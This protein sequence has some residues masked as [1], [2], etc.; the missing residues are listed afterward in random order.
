MKILRALLIGAA[1][2][3][4]AIAV[5]AFIW[6]LTLNLTILNR[7]AVKT[8]L[9]D[10]NLYSNLLDS[11]FQTTLSQQTTQLEGLLTPDILKTAL[12]NTFQPSYIQTQSETALDS[13]YNW[14]EGTA[15]T[16]NFTIDIPAK[17]DTFIQELTK[18][19]T[20]KVAALP[21]CTD[22]QLVLQEA[23]C[24]PASVTPEQFSKEIA[25]NSVASADFFDKPLTGENLIGE[26]TPQAAN[27]D[28]QADMQLLS[29]LP[30]YRQW[31][32]ILIIALPILIVIC[33]SLVILLSPD[34]LF[35]TIRLSRRLFFGAV[36]T[37]LA[38]LVMLY[39]GNNANSLPGLATQPAANLFIPVIQQVITGIATQLAITSGSFAATTG[40]AWLIT[41]LIRRKQ[42]HQQLLQPPAGTPQPPQPPTPPSTIN[43]V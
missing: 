26:S 40:A 34:K 2:L 18:V 28:T 14:I 23:T 20:P 13:T 15:T 1:T 27:P 30:V 31:V 8:W 37:F 6:L 22:L 32:N 25:E 38:A 10:S 41:A 7:Q 36:L 12:Q 29:Q 3:V 16:P 24:R 42:T 9:H 11:T 5:A 35:A 43:N 21:T 19:L 4:C 17:R 39:A 33:A